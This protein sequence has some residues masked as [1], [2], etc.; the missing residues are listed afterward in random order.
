MVSFGVQWN[1]PFFSTY[2]HVGVLW[3]LNEPIGGAD[4]AIRALKNAGKRIVFVSNN[5]AKSLQS[6]QE[7]IAG[8]G[9]SASEDDIV[10]PAISVVRYLQSINFQGLIFAICSN[11]FMSILRKA[12]YEVISGV[13][14]SYT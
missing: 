5:G 13:G 9:H 10:C 4:R 8:L 6:Y 2:Y 7:Q 1:T 3:T 12:G 11:T 14:F